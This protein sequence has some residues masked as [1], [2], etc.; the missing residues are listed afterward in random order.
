MPRLRKTLT[1]TL[2][3]SVAIRLAVP[4]LSLLAAST[5]FAQNIEDGQGLLP[6]RRI[7][8]YT[9]LG[10]DEN[11]IRRTVQRIVRQEGDA[12]GGWVYEWSSIGKHYEDLGDE[13]IRR[14]P[15]STPT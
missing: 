15:R 11:I 6:E 10:A 9:Y 2:C 12:P 13:I 7:R 8:A 4:L 1:R 5:G 3:G 14:G